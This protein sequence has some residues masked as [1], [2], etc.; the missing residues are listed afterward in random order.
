[1]LLT[2]HLFL[3]VLMVPFKTGPFYSYWKKKN[4]EEGRAITIKLGINKH[5]NKKQCRV[6]YMKLK[7]NGRS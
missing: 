7:D 5:K 2:G 1:M 4:K 6:V 3:E